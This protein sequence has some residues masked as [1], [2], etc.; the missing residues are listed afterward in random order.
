MSPTV[1]SPAS[2]A[3]EDGAKPSGAEPDGVSVGIAGDGGGSCARAATEVKV[4][5]TAR[6][7]RDRMRE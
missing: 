4:R 3:P 7:S 6:A 1:N 5:A 2:T